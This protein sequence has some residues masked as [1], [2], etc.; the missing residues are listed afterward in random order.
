[1]LPGELAFLEMQDRDK[2]QKKIGWHYHLAS[3]PVI[4]RLNEQEPIN[5]KISE[6]RLSWENDRET[7][8]QWYRDLIRT[9]ELFLDYQTNPTPTEEEHLNIVD[10][11]LKKILF[12]AEL[13]DSYFSEIDLYW[14]ENKSILKS[15]VLK[16][17]KSYEPELEAPFQMKPIS[18]NEEDDF[19]FFQ[20]LYEETLAHERTLDQK[21]HH[22][23]RNWESNR[24]AMVDMVILKMALAEMIT[25][26]SIPV[27]VTINEFIEISKQYSTP[28]SKQFINGI[29]DVLANELTSEGVIR[30]SG[31][32]LIDNK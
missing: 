12:K 27:K 7:L 24:I 11:I 13:V 1:M 29:L 4:Q 6:F 15:L 26:P 16:T 2:K 10:H 18:K 8:R 14:S 23:T 17:I 20:Q 25:F 28:K 19:A 9:D 22:R 32:G 3:N 30:K 31:R 21:I 5:L